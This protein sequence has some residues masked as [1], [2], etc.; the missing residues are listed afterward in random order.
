MSSVT[1][2]ADNPH[3][4][5]RAYDHEYRLL[6]VGVTHNLTQRFTTHRSQSPW[7]REMAT[8]RL[9]GPFVGLNARRRAMAVESSIIRTEKP[10]YNANPSEVGQRVGEIRKRTVRR[11]HETRG[12]CY[13]SFC[14]TCGGPQARLE[15]LIRER[16]AAS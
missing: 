11:L 8:V 2:L 1:H 13:V 12:W 4:V 5:Y 14:R 7:F 9:I 3:F 10:A 15:T 16:E 6:Y